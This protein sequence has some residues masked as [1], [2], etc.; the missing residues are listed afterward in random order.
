ML[1]PN[2]LLRRRTLR[3]KRNSL[4]PSLSSLYADFINRAIIIVM[5]YTP[6]PYYAAVEMLDSGRGFSSGS[7][8]IDTA[9]PP[10]SLSLSLSLS[11]FSPPPDPNENYRRGNF[12]AVEFF[13]EK[14]KSRGEMVHRLTAIGGF[15]RYVGCCGREE[16][17][18]RKRKEEEGRK[19]GLSNAE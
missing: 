11:L 14:R 12:G 7:T 2:R 9:Q 17:R 15:L 1:R 5:F 13:V 18:R 19:G 3:E 6:T 10:L 8:T 16:G 4:R